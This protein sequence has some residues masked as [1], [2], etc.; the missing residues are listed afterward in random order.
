MSRMQHDGVHFGETASQIDSECGHQ[1]R[2]P[3][4][5]CPA[6]MLQTNQHPNFSL[7]NSTRRRKVTGAFSVCTMSFPIRR[8]PSTTHTRAKHAWHKVAVTNT[9]LVVSLLSSGCPTYRFGGH[10]VVAEDRNLVPGL[11]QVC[12]T[13]QL[14][15]LVHGASKN[16]KVYLTFSKNHFSQKPSFSKHGVFVCCVCC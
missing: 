1:G 10:T 4:Q 15:I 11:R 2:T 6:P 16:W 8:A 9:F 7:I 3:V 12:G 13:V 5:F 14:N